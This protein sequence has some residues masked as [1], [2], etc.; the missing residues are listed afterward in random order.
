VILRHLEV[1]RFRGIRHA[2]FDGLSAELNLFHGANESGKSTLVEALHFAL[3]ERTRGQA[4]HKRAVRSWGASGDAP[5][6]QV[7]FET[8]EGVEWEVH[9]RFLDRPETEVYIGANTRLVG[10]PAEK[11]LRELLG[12]QRGPSSGPRPDDLG[13]WPIL[14]VRQGDAGLPTTE[15]MT[16]P[17]REQLA[18]TLSG[19]TGALLGLDGTPALLA[20]LQAQHDRW[21]TPTGRATAKLKAFEDAADDAKR[22]W[23]EAEEHLVAWQRALKDH[24]TATRRATDLDARVH[25]QRAQT[26][27]A[28][29]KARRAEL[30][31]ERLETAKVEAATA[32]LALEQA[33]AKLS[34]HADA[35]ARLSSALARTSQAR[36]RIEAAN[37]A[38]STLDADRSEV[39]ARLDAL[40]AERQQLQEDLL[41]LARIGGADVVVAQRDELVTR[42]EEAEALESRARALRDQLTTRGLS[43]AD[44]ERLGGLLDEVERL[45]DLRADRAARLTVSLIAPGTLDDAPLEPG[46]MVTVPVDQ[47]R[48]VVIEG[49]GTLRVDP[50][51]REDDRLDAML[52]D[53]ATLRDRIGAADEAEARSRLASWDALST[54]L[55]QVSE[56]LTVLA[57]SG[58]AAL[59]TEAARLSARLGRADGGDAG[60]PEELREAL[61]AVEA[62]R[63]K[64]EGSRTVLSQRLEEAG[65][66]LADARADGRVAEADAAAARTLQHE[67]GDLEGLH[68]DVDTARA[69][70][71]A[72][73]EHRDALAAEATDAGGAEAVR[74]AREEAAALVRVQGL[75]DEAHARVATLEARLRDQP[76]GLYEAARS[77]EAV[78]REARDAFGTTKREALAVR[79]LFDTLKA[80][81]QER[82]KEVAGPVQDAVAD[83]LRLL[84]PGS[85]LALDD[86]GEVIGLRTNGIVEN[87]ADLSGGTR[88]QLGVLV[89]L[90]L[91]R[92]LAGN[93]RLPVVLDDALVNADP[94][95]RARMVEVLR[96]ASDHLQLLVFTCHEEDFDRLAAPWRR[97]VAGRPPRGS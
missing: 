63:A 5:E 35:T 32:S 79:R 64:L 77:A 90:A 61:D 48:T 19:H 57:P 62:E 68:A 91:A 97:E 95:R 85:S 84:F 16:S 54:E 42:I 52:T 43:R 26:D 17:A 1:R 11:R 72:A 28:R 82:V 66:A 40:Q 93:E 58:I 30:A 89:R 24:H 2:R 65:S 31:L 78:Y 9:K 51:P 45:R 50:A 75:R 81:W 76:G 96:R 87:F 18:A 12:T 73:T 3:F 74:A 60:D 67:I 21:W 25:K 41:Q 88:E 14:M 39:R 71:L 44:A 37:T 69:K 4:E 27:R 10:E 29:A 59:K 13:I 55:T 49:I 83:G 38:R 47:A 46:R 20:R 56:Q 70:L 22:R 53:L 23:D 34:R 8:D 80:A 86:R 7:A 15:A 92:V 33:E 94:E 6:V 36:A